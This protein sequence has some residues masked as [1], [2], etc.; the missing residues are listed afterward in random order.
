MA[1][2]SK[3]QVLTNPEGS[4][5]PYQSQIKSTPF[6]TEGVRYV[7]STRKR[8]IK[9]SKKYT[10]LLEDCKRWQINKA[11]LATVK[12]KRSHSMRLFYCSKVSHASLPLRGN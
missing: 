2:E 4:V 8:Q 12:L 3:V 9:P 6:R 1:L 7:A 10:R 11:K 5:Q